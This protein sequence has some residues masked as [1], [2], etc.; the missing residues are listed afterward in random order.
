[1]S[2]KKMAE[3]FLRY[4]EAEKHDMVMAFEL[5]KA[6]GSALYPIV[7]LYKDEAEVPD[8][9][10]ING[11]IKQFLQEKKDMNMASSSHK[12]LSSI[13]SRFGKAMGKKP[14]NKVSRHD[15]RSWLN[16]TKNTRTGEPLHSET[17]SGYLTEVINFFNWCVE[18]K[19]IGRDANPTESVKKPKLTV[20]ELEER[21]NRKEILTVS[22]TEGLLAACVQQ[23]PHM[24]PRVAI[25]FFAG[26]RPEQE[27]AGVRDEDINMDRG[28]L[29]VRASKAKDRKART[30]KMTPNLIRWLKWGYSHGHRLPV[31]LTSEEWKN[32]WEKLRKS[33]DLY[34]ENWPHDTNRHS[35]CSYH[36]EKFG[37][38]DT[39]KAMGHSTNDM[40]W[41]NYISPVEP[42]EAAEY[43]NLMPPV[44]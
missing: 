10:E 31:G 29:K 35:F 12:N 11:L 9:P 26:L 4:T 22:E 28:T 40:M 16:N 30:I 34:G 25:L 41:D 43:F 39:Q 38:K 44:S 2:R 14:V 15:I 5:A 24:V 18:T 13:I 20:E 6:R 33:V 1:V 27:G 37:E 19:V 36:F 7:A 23:Y 8:G 32:R 42:H 3:S 21:E 17:K